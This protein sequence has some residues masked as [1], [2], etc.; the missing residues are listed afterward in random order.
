VIFE[1]ERTFVALKESLDDED[2]TRLSDID[3]VC[4]G[5]NEFIAANDII[6]GSIKIKD[7]ATVFKESV[8]NGEILGEDVNTVI[9]EMRPL[10]FGLK[11]IILKEIELSDKDID[12][13]RFFFDETAFDN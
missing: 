3:V 8:Y 12:I 11:N 1:C 10:Y 9:K 4:H 2:L 6:S 7:L 5:I 13:Q